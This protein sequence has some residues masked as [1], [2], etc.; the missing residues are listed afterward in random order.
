[1]ETSRAL[2]LTVLRA[3][4]TRLLAAS[5]VTLSLS[6]APAVAAEDNVAEDGGA[7]EAEGDEEESGKIQV[8]ET[9][10]DRVGLIVLGFL[11]AI[12]VGG[13]ITSRRQLKGERPQASGEF[14]WR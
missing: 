3:R 9:P 11:G 8:A 10:R 5:V 2:T 14:R 4:A 1:M 7:I 6:A 12:T 13:A